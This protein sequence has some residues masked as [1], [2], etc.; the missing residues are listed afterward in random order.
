MKF[1][2]V[3]AILREEDEDK[4]IKI[5]KESGACGVTILSAKG[6]GLKE[7]KGFLGV[8]IENIETTLLF[9]SSRK[10]ALSIIRSLNEDLK[11]NQGGHGIAFT[12]PIDHI[13][14]IDAKQIEKFEEKDF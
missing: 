11:L 8:S 5:A 2:A 4:A 3:I 10:V 7:K 12:L 14:G 9:V 6:L 1:C 13:M